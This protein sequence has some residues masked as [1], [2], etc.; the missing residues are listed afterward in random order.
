MEINQ[1]GHIESGI[2]CDS[3][4]FRKFR[5]DHSIIPRRLGTEVAAE[6]TREFGSAGAQDPKGQ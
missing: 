5:V 6:K 2:V 4:E 1:E 3:K